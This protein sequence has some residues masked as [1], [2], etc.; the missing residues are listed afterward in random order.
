MAANALLDALPLNH[1][2]Q[3]LRLAKA[4]A[5]IRKTQRD[6]AA[7]R[8]SHAKARRRQLRRLGIRLERLRCCIPGPSG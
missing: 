6:N 2:D 1:E 7:A 3:N 5:Q 4:A 8:A